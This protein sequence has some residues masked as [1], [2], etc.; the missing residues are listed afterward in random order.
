MIRHHSLNEHNIYYKSEGK[1]AAPI[2]YDMN[3]TEKAGRASMMIEVTAMANG[4]IGNIGYLIGSCFARGFPAV[5]REFNLNFLSLPALPS[6][7]VAGACSDP[8]VVLREIDCGKK[9]KYYYI[10]HFGKTAKQGVSVSL[11]GSPSSVEF[12]AYGKSKKIEGG[13]LTFNA[14]PFQL[15]ALRVK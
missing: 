2:G 13:R 3:D 9:G 8:E 6:K 5:A 7:V 10:V 15:L 14:K 12:P 4:D 11:P 1:N